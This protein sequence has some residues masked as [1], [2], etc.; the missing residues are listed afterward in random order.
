MEDKN[1]TVSR[2]MLT[3]SSSCLYMSPLC[4]I[5]TEQPN[6][7]TDIDEIIKALKAGCKK[8]PDFYLNLFYARKLKPDESIATYC[9]E[10]EGLL[11]K[12][13]PGLEEASKSSLLRAR[14]IA[15]VP[16][17]VKNFMELLSDKS[18]KK[19]VTI[20]YKSVDYKWISTK[21]DDEA[22]LVN[23]LNA[24]SFKS[25]S[26]KFNGC[27]FYCKRPGHR[28]SECRK[29]QYD[30]KNKPRS[31][32]SSIYDRFK[33]SNI[34]HSERRVHWDN[35][36]KHNDPEW[37]EPEEEQVNSLE[38][39]CN[40]FKVNTLQRV[41]INI[42]L[43]GFNTK[44]NMLIDSGSSGSFI[45]PAKL[46]VEMRNYL[47]TLKRNPE[48]MANSSFSITGLNIKSA[49]VTKQCECVIGNVNINTNS[50]YK[51]HRFIFAD[52][53]EDGILGIDF[54]MKFDAVLDY[55][56]RRVT[57]KQDENDVH[58][59]YINENES[60]NEPKGYKVL[61]TVKRIVK[62]KTEIVLKCRANPELIGREMMFE[63]T[64]FKEE[65]S[66][67][68]LVFGKCLNEVDENGEV[69]V[70]GINASE[71]EVELESGSEVGSLEDVEI[72]NTEVNLEYKL[73]KKIDLSKLKI[74]EKLTVEQRYKLV[75]LILK[76]EKAFKWT[77]DDIC[78][79]DLTKHE[80][81][82]GD[83]NPIK[84]RAYRLPQA[85][86]DE[87]K[88]DESGKRESRFCIHFRKLNEATIK[89]DALG[90]AWFFTCLDMDSGYWQIQLSEESKEKTAFCANNKLFEFNVMSFGLC[91]APP[92]FQRL[93]DDL[94]KNLTWVACLVY[95][96]DVIVFEEA[97]LKLKPS[98]CKFAME[99]V[100]YLGFKITKDG[101]KPDPSKTE[102]I[103]NLPAQQNKGDVLRFLDF[104]NPFELFCDA[105]ATHVGAV[106]VQR[107][108]GVAHPVAFAS[109]QLIK[110]E[111]NYS[112]SERELLA[113][114]WATRTYNSYIYGRHIKIYSDHKPIKLDYEILY[115]PGKL[116]F[117]ADQL[118]RP[119]TETSNVE[120]KTLEYQ[121]NID[122][123]K[124]QENDKLNHDSIIAGHLS[125][126]RTLQSIANKYVWP[127][128]R[129]NV[130]DYCSSCDKCQKFK[131]KNTSNVKP[132]ITI[133]VDKPWDLTI[134]QNIVWTIDTTGKT[135]VN[136]AT[137]RIVSVFGTPQAFI[138]DQGR[139]FESQ[140]FKYFCDQNKIKKLRKTAYHP[141]CNGLTE[142]TIRTIKQM[143][144]I[145][146]NDSHD[147]WDE[148]LQS[149]IFA[150]NN[151]R[152]LTTNVAPN[153]IVFGKLMKSS[154]DRLCGIDRTSVNQDENFVEKIQDKMRKSQENQKRQYDSKVRDQIKFNIGDLVILVNSRQRPGQERSFEPKFIGP[155]KIL[156][157]V[158]DVN[159][160]IVDVNNQKSTLVVHYNRMR[161]YNERKP[162]E[163]SNNLV[164]LNKP[165]TKFSPIDEE[166]DINNQI[167]IQALVNNRSISVP[168]INKENLM[169]V[170]SK[171]LNVVSRNSDILSETLTDL[172]DEMTEENQAKTS[173]TR[174]IQQID[175]INERRLN[176]N[177]SESQLEA[178]SDESEK[179]E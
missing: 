16:E 113:V 92:T 109:R 127:E 102:A 32:Q 105:S 2:K 141:Q 130:F 153:V 142:R 177:L 46:P 143:L 154:F 114:V 14:L 62:P 29:K 138:T 30:E 125:Y 124:E 158:T 139:N 168:N 119:S 54:L 24:V 145:Y 95:L 120:V 65:W 37:D 78:L 61:A 174:N 161:K 110:Q 133:T 104:N 137:D 31:G 134:S 155:Y 42:E 162:E 140:K 166:A 57:I 106:L 149:V 25:Q 152:H 132:L 58:L 115:Y 71:K 179:S 6:Q 44:V 126:D 129:A 136:F 41:S 67:N 10:I 60:K 112:A 170:N 79:T 3:T 96:D 156:E 173:T 86:Q 11:S 128:M 160:K 52:V 175:S 84:Q 98:K 77:E 28:I 116:N 144:C 108:N 33:R 118:S 36:N 72:M 18:W 80:I 107:I 64:S 1:L 38:V 39:A 45:N 83:T 27:C 151:T 90:G 93:M 34:F 51:N 165:L 43:G 167:W 103:V 172:I 5:G 169:N 171:P 76:H 66:K 20:F 4:S 135:T 89:V 23:K 9:H 56:H 176:K 26:Q 147:N 47:E 13:M 111:R 101:L 97:N 68:G 131:I 87:K 48:Q 91:N 85:A 17:N 100:S 63:P 148:C 159:F 75:K 21:V 74:S 94:L 22:V 157:Q 123:E 49:L 69:F 121:A 117:M 59:N 163:M 40:G 73:G 8:S 82:T 150:Y 35:R 19:L 15:N 99:E 12:G 70:I 88:A 146:V 7:K 122:C 164:A 53:A 178:S 81:K 55:K 50:W